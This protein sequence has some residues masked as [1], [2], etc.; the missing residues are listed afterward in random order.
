MASVFTIGEAV[1]LKELKSNPSLNGALKLLLGIL[2]MKLE[3]GITSG[4]EVQQQ[5]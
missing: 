2:I 4:Y 3:E 1:Q 5:Q